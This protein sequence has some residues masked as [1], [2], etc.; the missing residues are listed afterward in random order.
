MDDHDDETPAK[1]SSQHSGRVAGIAVAAALAGSAAGCDRS[2]PATE[3]PAER[4]DAELDDA[5]DPETTE[6]ETTEPETT[7]PETTEPAD[8]ADDASE[9]DDGVAP[10]GEGDW[11]NPG[12]VRG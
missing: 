8:E 7:E 12:S 1:P 6:P 2:T 11:S 3:P 10:D 5:D 9:A 4:G